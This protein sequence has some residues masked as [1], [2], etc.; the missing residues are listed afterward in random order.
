[1]LINGALALLA[2]PNI[3]DKGYHAK[4]DA[5]RAGKQLVLQP[6]FAESDKHFI[7]IQALLSVS[8][9]TDRD[10]NERTV[11]VSKRSWY[12]KQGFQPC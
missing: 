1:M 6:A 12:V 2:F 8:V 11:N 4:A 10:R 3:N 5:H 7:R 9:A